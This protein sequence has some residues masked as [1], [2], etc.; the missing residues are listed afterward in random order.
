[1]LPPVPCECALLPAPAAH[2]LKT[3][4]GLRY[5]PEVLGKAAVYSTLRML[6]QHLQ[7]FMDVSAEDIRE[8]MGLAVADAAGEPGGGEAAGISWSELTVL[9][10]G[11]AEMIGEGEGGCVDFIKVMHRQG[12]G[13]CCLLRRPQKV[14]RDG[15]SCQ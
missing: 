8:R 2:S 4:L 14:V 5:A 1:M 6:Q 3:P 12:Q 15:G 10:A 13:R 11:A 7:Q 9:G